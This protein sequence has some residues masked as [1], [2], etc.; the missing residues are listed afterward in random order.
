MNVPS[1][2]FLGLHITEPFTWLTNW[3]VACFVFGYGHFLYHDKLADATQKFWSVF[4]VFIGLASLT[5]GTAHGFIT[6][7]GRNF[8]Y[9]AWILTGIAVFAAELA[10]LQLVENNRVK[11][12]L[13]YFI[14]AQLM[15]MVSS[16]MFLHNF[17]SVRINS[18]VGL[19]GI[20]V[21]ISVWHYRKFKDRRSLLI[22]LGIFSNLLPGFIH[23]YK[24]SYN[25]WFNFN[26]ISH[27][28]M[29][30]CFYI[31]YRGAK[32]NVSTQVEKSLS[33]VTA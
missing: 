10:S 24:I 31:L 27:I 9:A 32:L 20:I 5:G 8:H 19:M 22:T 2:E 3:L 11:T 1:V 4:F 15:V 26:D 13:R 25:Q 7:V 6:Y 12:Y 16:V 30:G 18:A 29:I 33:K 21:P 23:A 28:I 14:Y 17:N